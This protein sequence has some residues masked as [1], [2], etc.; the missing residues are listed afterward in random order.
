MAYGYLANPRERLCLPGT[1]S[2]PRADNQPPSKDPAAV[3]YLFL[4]LLAATALFWATV[5]LLRGGLAGTSMLMLLAASCFGY[6]FFHASI[7]LPISIDRIMFLVL[8]GQ[9]IVYRQWGWTDPKPLTKADYVLIALLAVVAGSAFTHD[10][11]AEKA[12]PISHLVLFYLMPA[13]MY[14]IARQTRW[15]ERSAWILFGS[16]A[17]FGIYLAVTAVAETRDM[18]Y[19]VYPKY[20]ASPEF[21]DYFGRGRGPFLSPMANGFVQALALCAALIIWPRL[22][23][24]TQLVALAVSPIY[25]LGIYS[26]LTRSVWMGAGAGLLIVFGLSLPKRWR[27]SFTVAATVVCVA[28]PVIGWD[29]LMVFKREKGVD[30]EVSADSAKLRPIL[31]P[32][33]GGCSRTIRWWAAVTD[34][35]AARCPPT[36]TTFDR[37]AV[38]NGPPLCA[39]Q[40][41]PGNADRNGIDRHDPVCRAAVLLGNIRL[42]AVGQPARTA[43]DAKHGAAVFSHAGCL[44]S[45]R[46][47]PRHVANSDGQPDPV[48]PGWRDHRLI[49]RGR[50]RA[51]L[52]QAGVELL[53]PHGRDAKGRAVI[54]CRARGSS[55][56][57]STPARS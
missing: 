7:G 30:A 6:D 55:T 53:E 44:S 33:P 9:Y 22:P 12:K 41:L 3:E 52:R 5:L 54:S 39:A 29:N 48:L 8:I 15:S 28:I 10:Y 50:A 16:L 25:L 14:W 43:V 18:W 57:S 37:V 56:A 2:G 19:L 20:I 45:Q 51:S 46:H 40:R 31:A 23:R 1:V 49:A 27:T 17:A 26:T 4:A 24:P 21:P 36:C 47:V 11:M 38:G 32:W 34:N 13:V 35:I 42:A